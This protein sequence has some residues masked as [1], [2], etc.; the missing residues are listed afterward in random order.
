[1]NS[2]FFLRIGMISRLLVLGTAVFLLGGCQDGGVQVTNAPSPAKENAVPEYKDNFPEFSGTNAYNRVVYLVSLG[3]RT[4]GSKGLEESVRFLE[5]EMARFGWKTKRQ[6]FT[7]A[8]VAGKKTF[9]NLRA[10]WGKDADFDI[11]AVGVMGCHIDTKEFDFPFVGANDGASHTAVMLELAR[12]MGKEPQAWKGIEIVFFDGEESFAEHMDPE[13]DGLYGSRYY[14]NSISG[15][16]PR[17]M[18]NLDMLGAKKLRIAIPADTPQEMY[19]LYRDTRMSLKE[20]ED[21]FGISYGTIWD[22]HYPF[23]QAGVP[24]LN[25]IGEFQD[26]NWWHTPNDTLD[27]I[28]AKS[29]ERSGKFIFA[30]LKRLPGLPVSPSGN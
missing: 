21:V 19:A 12:L 25:F 17:W 20:S 28:S 11:P 4:P 5:K 26:S 8:T 14:V 9:T 23:M 7:Q 18:V 24:T 3:E 29:L 16:L 27:I 13:K 22:D 15:K 6:T 30:F 1:M 2:L 10:R